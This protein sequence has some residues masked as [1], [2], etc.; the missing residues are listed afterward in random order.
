MGGCGPAHGH[1]RILAVIESLDADLVALQEVLLP[2]K[3][4]TVEDLARETGM[5]VLPGPTLMRGDAEYGN[6][7]LSSVPI[8]RVLA[9]DL[10]VDG[11]EPRGA[12]LVSMDEGSV[13][14]TFI[15]SHLGLRPWERV[16]QM[17]T[18]MQEM[19]SMDAAKVFLG[20]VNEW[21]PWSPVFRG[22]RAVFGRQ[23]APPR[24]FPSGCPLL[25]FDRIL[26][27]AGFFASR[28]RAIRTPVT[29]WAS[30]HLP[31]RASLK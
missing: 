1:G 3:G 26:A 24:T 25:A 31:V 13:P 21:N 15:A 27:P 28:P 2:W 20:D 10:T 4:F 5:Q 7:L 16:R 12:V 9:L 19:L 14:V 8:Q 22:L 30:D 17:K 29:R 18:L 23:P 11:Y 6:V